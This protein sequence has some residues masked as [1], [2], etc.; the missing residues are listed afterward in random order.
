MIPWRK[1]VVS[2]RFRRLPRWVV[3]CLALLIPLL[4]GCGDYCLFCDGQGGGGGGGGNGTEQVC[5]NVFSGLAA[6]QAAL[7]LAVVDTFQEPRVAD[8]RLSLAV[9]P[10]GMSFKYGTNRTADPGDVIL[11]DQQ[12]S[13]IYVYEFGTPETRRSLGAGVGGVSGVALLR[14]TIDTDTDADLL[15]FTVEAEN[16]LYIY[17]LAGSTDPVPITNQVLRSFFGGRDFFESPTALAVSADAENAV[18]FVLNDNGTNSSV[19]RLSMS[20]PIPIPDTNSLQTVATMTES[21]RLLVD[22]A[23]FAQTDTLYVSK[24]TEGEQLTVGWVYRIVNAS[25]RT[26][27]VNLNPNSTFIAG[28]GAPT[29]LTAAFTNKTGT[30]AAL[31]VLTEGDGQVLQYDIASGG[32]PE[33]AFFLGDVSVY[34]LAIAYDCTNER[35][36]MTDVP[37]N[38]DISRTFFEAFPSL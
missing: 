30:T 35:L 11:A 7:N 12:A 17:D 8:D 24:K 34:P 3:C 36:V 15:F 38:P 29:G 13:D 1:N 2:K 21:S 28:G 20:L 31:L 33:N 26:G 6:Y 23:F 10:N 37:F 5:D 32:S 9:V 22:I 14:Y 18:V 27:S 25:D 19:R 16:T 4:A